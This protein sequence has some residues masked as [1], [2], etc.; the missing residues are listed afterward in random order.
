MARGGSRRR[1]SRRQRAVKAGE[2]DLEMSARARL[3]TGWLTLFVIG[4]D[5]F[6]VSP[7]LPPIAG[8]F[9]LSASAAGLCATVFSAFYMVSAP[10]FGT[11]ADRLGRRRI[12]T[13]C[14]AGFALANGLTGST[15]GFA[16]LIAWRGLAGIAAAGVTP[17][18]YAGVGDEAPPARRAT[19]LALAVSG[20]LLA[21][22]IGAPA[23]AL[24]GAG[25]GWRAPF[26]VI[27][28]LSLLLAAANRFAWPAR[29]AA[30]ASAT[31]D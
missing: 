8:E 19:W 31:A 22:S 7:L 13:F 2:P 17:L 12:L 15:P 25:W 14:L 20:L 1:R 3:A 10:L 28:G 26:L 21:L 18:I 16:W 24:I 11:L 9:R 27:A 29:A 5:L 4:T 30:A 6:V 23:G